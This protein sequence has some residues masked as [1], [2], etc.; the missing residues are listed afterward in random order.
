MSERSALE[1]TVN[2]IAGLGRCGAK[3]VYDMGCGLGRHTILLARQGFS[4]VAS[5]VSSRAL[6]ATA[7][8]LKAAKLDGQVVRADM[9]S[10]P[11]SDEYFDAI[12]AIGVMEHDTRAGIEKTISEI[13]RSLRP[14]GHDAHG[15]SAAQESAPQIDG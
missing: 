14:G 2:W 8:K 1:I 4:V 11:F 12:L 10:I 5:D 15:L 7:Q 3:R 13:F 9:K 6:E